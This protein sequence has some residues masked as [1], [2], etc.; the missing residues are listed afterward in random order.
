MATP[1]RPNQ[2]AETDD[3]QMTG[4]ESVEASP[5]SDTPSDA[6][7]TASAVPGDET[8]TPALLD[9]ESKILDAEV[10]SW[11]EQAAEDADRKRA[12]E[13]IETVEADEILEALGDDSPQSQDRSDV[14]DAEIIEDTRPEPTPPPAPSAPPPTP[15]K[16]GG[17]FFGMA[18]GGVVAAAAGYALATFNPIPGLLPAPAPSAE[19][20][21]AMQALTTRIGA[22][23]EATL[24]DRVAAL[25]SRPVAA[26]PDLAPV[27]DAIAA[28]EARLATLEAAG[29]IISADGVPSDLVATVKALRAEMDVLKLEE[30]DA[31]AGV[32]AMVDEAKAQIAEAEASAA[33][34]KAEAE[35][36][37]R[38]A[39]AKASVGRLTA[40]LESGSPFADALPDLA[41][42]D[43]PDILTQSAETGVP[44]SAVLIAGFPVAARAALD[45]SIRSNIGDN[46]TDRAASFLRSATGA[47]SLTPQEGDGPDAVLSRAEAAVKAG[48]LQTA[49]TELQ[50]LPDAGKAAMAEWSAMAQ[51]RLDA[52]SA[53]AALAAAVEG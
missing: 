31:R 4:P 51:H 22:L 39:L 14:T 37:A 15:K 42:F 8:V 21:A 3:G 52:A 53:I 26:E 5:S 24:A 47:R 18:L 20:Q 25:E 28:L 44:S 41:G 2:E 10:A 36:T 40:A 34:M 32:L 29:P 38:I 17:G 23:E 12:D 35:E 48:D 33:A 1:V 49:L 6:A 43:V 19:E 9:D 30:G 46:W 11:A 16:S 27:T 13:F 7:D 45:T 50:A